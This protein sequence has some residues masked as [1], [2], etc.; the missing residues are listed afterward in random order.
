MTVGS[1]HFLLQDGGSGLHGRNL[2]TVTIE[3]AGRRHYII[4]NTFAVKDQLKEAGCKWD[5]DRKAWWTGKRELADQLQSSLSGASSS[6][7]DAR[8]GDDPEKITVVAKARYKDRVYFVRW[9]GHTKR[10]AEAARL[11]SFDGKLDFW[12]DLAEIQIIKTYGRKNFRS[13]RI[14]YPT[15]GSIR[16]FAE[17]AKQ[18]KA[19]GYDDVR[20]YRAEKSDR[21]RGCGGAI[22]DAPGHSAMGG[23]CGECAFDEYDC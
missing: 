6:S 9:M 3:T 13:G 1:W 23:Y 8:S 7:S 18:A 2:L 21:C 11:V 19:E 4:G 5:P 14:E 17:Q 22:V 10:G 15:L 16:E 20:E 12:K